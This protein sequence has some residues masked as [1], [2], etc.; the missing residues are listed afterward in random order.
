M[1]SRLGTGARWSNALFTC[2]HD[3]VTAYGTGAAGVLDLHQGGAAGVLN[4]IDKNS[5]DCADTAVSVLWHCDTSG[6]AVSILRRRH[7]MID[8][9]VRVGRRAELG[10]AH[11]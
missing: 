10:R 4:D 3:V 5:S 9:H 8:Q 7:K 6:A 11:T 1:A 2:D